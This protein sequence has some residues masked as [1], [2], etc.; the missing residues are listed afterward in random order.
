M[1]KILLSDSKV[2]ENYGK[3]YIVAEVNSSHNGNINIAKQM[4]DK[5]KEIGCDCVKFQSWTPESL[6][7]KSYYNE[8]PIS[9]RIVK[10]F[11][12]DEGQLNELITYCGEKEISFS[13]T[14]YSEKEVDFLSEH[15][16]IPFI[17]ISSMEINNYKF[18]KYI[19]RKNFPVVLST[20]MADIDEIQKA[21][22]IISDV[23]ND[24]ICILHCVSNYPAAP[25]SINLNNIVGLREKFTDF[26][27]G[28]SDHTIGTEVASAA[29]ALGVCLIEK[30]FTLDKSIIGMDNQMAAEPKEMRAIVESCAN[31]Y[32]AMG[33]KKR[34]VSEEEL[35]QRKKMRRSLIASRD[36]SVGDILT[37]NDL[38]A[39]RPG[40]GL[41]PSMISELIGHVMVRNVAADT[42]IMREDYK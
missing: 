8:N 29:V 7:S 23:G 28:Y 14:P 22:K 9:K 4:I 1:K 31:V 11:S 37:E 24:K 17:K 12:F 33:L 10:K 5:A 42:L 19:G 38:D 3:P 32:S 16:D 20:G 18:L 25:Q 26:P 40:I 13:S 39:K 21:V 15:K 27:I 36:L 2:L 6:Y 35:L 34:I 30:H 41:P